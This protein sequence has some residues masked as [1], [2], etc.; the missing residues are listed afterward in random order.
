MDRIGDD[1]VCGSRGISEGVGALGAADV[2]V[3]VIAMEAPF[4]A[5]VLLL[6][7]NKID[8]DRRGLSW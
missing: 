2:V 8:C 7:A 1:N 4:L 6:F 5:V 3:V